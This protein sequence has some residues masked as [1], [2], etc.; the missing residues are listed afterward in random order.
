MLRSPGR[1]RRAPAFSDN[2]D[3]GPS[4]P[5]TFFV[6]WYPDQTHSLLCL[7]ITNLIIGQRSL[8]KHRLDR[9]DDSIS[10]RERSSGRIIQIHM[11]LACAKP[12]CV[13]LGS[14][15]PKVLTATSRPEESHR[16]LLSTSSSII[17]A[18]EYR[19]NHRDITRR[20]YSF[21]GKG[22]DTHFNK[23]KRSLSE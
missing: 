11:T 10:T 16:K 15:R 20:A 2:A 14:V 6:Q 19:V 21:S 1:K 17:N 9:F 5:L 3:L 18:R 23:P 22:I 7:I 13:G 4:L 12:Y 8:S